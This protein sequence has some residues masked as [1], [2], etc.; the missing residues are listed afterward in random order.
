MSFRTGGE[1]VFQHAAGVPGVRVQAEVGC[2]R[3]GCPKELDQGALP[4]S[5]VDIRIDR[6]RASTI[7]PHWARSGVFMVH[8]DLDK[9]RWVNAGTP[10][11]PALQ[12]HFIT[13]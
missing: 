4:D 12:P 3:C 9:T 13:L 11:G 7:V 2:N 5:F 10:F 6:P 8:L 1:V